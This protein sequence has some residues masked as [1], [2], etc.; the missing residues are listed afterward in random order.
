MLVRKII[1]KRYLLPLLLKVLHHQLHHLPLLH[2]T[3]LKRLL[4]NFVPDDTLDTFFLDDDKNAASKSDD[5]PVA[6]IYSDSDDERDG[7]P[8]VATFQDY[9]DND[10]PSIDDHKRAAV[11]SPGDD[12]SS[13]DEDFVKKQITV[14]KTDITSS[15]EN[16]QVVPDSLPAEENKL[17]EPKEESSYVHNLEFEDLSI[18]ENSLK[19]SSAAP[20]DDFTLR[21][22]SLSSTEN[23]D[24]QTKKLK[25]KVK[26]EGKSKKKHKKHSRDEEKKKS[27]KRTEKKDKELEEF[28]GGVAT[29]PKGGADYESI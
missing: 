13:D 28:L 5:V 16:L 7:N 10:S 17:D 23:D 9:E 12:V 24:V 21:K 8:M 4:K 19:K 1:N 2:P 6:E 27:K 18:L 20:S 25:N 14:N 26:G 29:D 11:F 3:K 22:E 15:R